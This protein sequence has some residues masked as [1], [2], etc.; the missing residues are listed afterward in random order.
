M[1]QKS[2]V[3]VGAATRVVHSHVVMEPELMVVTRVL[4][5]RGRELD[6]RHAAVPAAVAAES[7]GL[8]SRSR[9]LTLFLQ[10]SHLC[11]VQRLLWSSSEARRGRHAPRVGVLG[12]QVFDRH[13]HVLLGMGED[14]V[15][16]NWL[17]ISYLLVGLVAKV[18]TSLE[19]GRCRR[20]VATG[21]GIAAVVLEGEDTKVFYV[22][23]DEI[24]PATDSQLEPRE[25]V[26]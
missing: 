23:P 15:S 4:D 10:S 7:T 1:E 16:G 14:Q 24:S 18:G 13:G 2:T 12:S 11:F 9:A 8:G 21:R 17:Q 19:L 6:K 22:D 3:Q 26:I 20:A 5:E 25:A